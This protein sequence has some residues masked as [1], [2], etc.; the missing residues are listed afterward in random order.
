MRSL[1]LIWLVAILAVVA[2]CPFFS[3]LKLENVSLLSLTPTS[4]AG[5][6]NS[7][8]A[9]NATALALFSAG[10][11][12][13]G[14]YFLR[15][16]RSITSFTSQQSFS[17]LNSIKSSMN[18][19]V[20]GIKNFLVKNSDAIKTGSDIAGWVSLG[21]FVAGALLSLTGVG[22]V[23]GVPLMT[24]AFAVGVGSAAADLAVGA[25]RQSAGVADT[26][27]YIRM[28]F[29][30]LAFL[31]GGKAA[32]QAGKVAVKQ[33]AKYAG[34][35]IAEEAAKK[36]TP[37]ELVTFA[38]FLEGRALKPQVEARLID[39]LQRL[40]IGSIDKGMERAFRTGNVHEMFKGS[41]FPKHPDISFMNGR[42]NI[43]IK[44]LKANEVFYL[45]GMI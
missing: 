22:A 45:C 33:I 37:R 32:G 44:P 31:P 15:R 16:G 35:E 19:A 40:G 7:S 36:L 6:T 17:V 18:G 43:E 42:L 30:P 27:D 24:A 38:S 34:K 9:T 13:A 25:A 3:L 26:D 39:K 5:A 29:A 10:A 28:G 8:V 2:F 11:A 12:G 41:N 20:D 1:S 23:V 4:G 21:L 14:Y